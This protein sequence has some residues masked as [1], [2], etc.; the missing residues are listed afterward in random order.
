MGAQL[1][2]VPAPRTVRRPT[3]IL[4]GFP[5]R[6]PEEYADLGALA[7][8]LKALSGGAEISLRMGSAF[9]PDFDEQ[10][11][12]ITASSAGSYLATIGGP[13]ATE[14]DHARACLD[15]TRVLP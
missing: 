13:W 1:R 8:R 7:E 10:F 15:L 14:A 6:D 5:S 4:P 12:S 2:L 3:L 9:Y 11:A